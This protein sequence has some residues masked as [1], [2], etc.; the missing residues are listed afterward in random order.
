MITADT[1][2]VLEVTVQPPVSRDE[3]GLAHRVNRLSAPISL[4]WQIIVL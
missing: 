3:Q 2:S 4:C 1:A